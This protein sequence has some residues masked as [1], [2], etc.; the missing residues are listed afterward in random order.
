MVR[1]A[2]QSNTSQL[3]QQI[4]D[5][6]LYNMTLIIHE[7]LRKKGKATTTRTVMGSS[8][9][10]D[11]FFLFKFTALCELCCVALSFCRVTLSL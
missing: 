10:R 3:A 4:E 1:K 8:P 5:V 11:S 2:R 9:T 6:L 7:M